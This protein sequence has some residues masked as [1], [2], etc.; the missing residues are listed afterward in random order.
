ML[1]STQPFR[2]ARKPFKPDASVH[3]QLEAAWEGISKCPRCGN[4]PQPPLPALRCLSRV[5]IKSHI[6][7]RK[8][9]STRL[10]FSRSDSF[11]GC[12]HSQDAFV[13]ALFDRLPPRSFISQKLCTVHNRLSHAAPSHSYVIC[14]CSALRLWG[15]CLET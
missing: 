5:L 8:A 4:P 3:R 7:R 15:S 13:A 9:G 12:L 10:S 1:H 11:T 6:S 14:L 2:Q